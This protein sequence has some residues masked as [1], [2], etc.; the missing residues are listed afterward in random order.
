M[1]ILPSEGYSFLNA[2]LFICP[3]LGVVF[4]R[5]YISHFQYCI[6]SRN[7][8]PYQPIE[9]GFVPVKIFKCLIRLAWNGIAAYNTAN[10]DQAG[11]PQ[12]ADICFPGRA[13]ETFPRPGNVFPRSTTVSYKYGSSSIYTAAFLYQSM[14][15]VLVKL[16]R[17]YLSRPIPPSDST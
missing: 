1:V 11:I 9:K 6:S 13:W 10:A 15:L 12:Q 3:G 2:I 17:V 5:S 8:E 7:A 14:T 4:F 16:N